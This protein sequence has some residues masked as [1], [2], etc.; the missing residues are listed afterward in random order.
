MIEL[1]ESS[2]L[3]DILNKNK[4]GY[5]MKKKY[6]QT[7]A[8]CLAAAVFMSGCSNPFSKKKDD[9][10]IEPVSYQL[11]PVAKENLEEGMFY[12]KVDD[13]FYKVHM[14]ETNIKEDNLIAKK[15]DPSR[16]IAFTKDDA[17][18]PTVYKDDTLVYYSQSQISEF[19]WERMKDN[20]YSVGYFNLKDDT[21]GKVKYT[22]GESGYAHN[23]SLASAFSQIPVQSETSL[24]L[25]DRIGGSAITP[26]NLTDAGSISGLKV[27]SPA[28]IDLYL[29]T[30][31]FEIPA[32]VDTHIL[33]SM[34]LYQTN[35]FALNKDGYAEIKIP[36]YFLSGY[37]FINGIGVFKYVANDR[38]DGIAGIDF[39]VPYFYEDES[40]KKITLEEWK[41][42][43][44]QETTEIE[45]EKAG[46]SFTLSIDSTQ[47]S[48][49]MD[50]LY[51]LF[52]GED[53]SNI[54][55]K[56]PK[57][58][59]ISPDGEE[60]RF[61]SKN[62][63]GRKCLSLLM[64]GMKSG[65]WLV[66]IYNLADR[67]YDIVSS[68]SSGNADSFVH[69]GNGKGS[70]KVHTDGISGMAT[71]D[72]TWE[73]SDHAVD[74]A[75]II[76]PSGNEYLYSRTNT[77]G[78]SEGFTSTYGHLSLTLP[79]IEPGEWELNVTGEKLGRVWFRFTQSDNLQAQPQEE[80]QLPSAEGTDDT[81]EME[82]EPDAELETE[83]SEGE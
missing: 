66:K 78:V 4:G 9:K 33:S 56:E 74:Q 43:T 44:G 65:D 29:G 82:T 34:E 64:D 28:N 81:V 83:V 30:Q 5:T 55:Y 19:T 17:L 31:H 14:G 26:T 32:T 6:I 68:I 52:E 8:L 12:A 75:T 47:E 3:F 41:K 46:S 54:F 2:S 15:E 70:I 69:S 53:T 39:S 18:I 21:N 61:E 38:A 67:P 51:D 73:N 48:Y 36:D 72:V 45:E 71:V 50:I 13:Q 24:I 10:E 42:L 79:S 60:I 35:E 37:Y 80:T 76:S 1:D 27:D 23:S 22:I 16:V 25:I 59:I 77:E 63:D 62:K 57:A 20:G 7:L 58:K 49:T 11:T 40:G